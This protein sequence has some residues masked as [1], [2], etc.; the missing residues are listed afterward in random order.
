MT[1]LTAAVAGAA[2]VTFVAPQHGGQA[3]GPALIE[4]ATDAAAV[5]RVEF[6]VDGK[7]VG[8]ARKEPWRIAHDFGTS[9]A[10]R[11]IVAKVFSHGFTHVDTG[12]VTTM[13][14]TAGESIDVDLVEV[15]LRIRAAK[16]ITPADLKLIENKVEQ[17]IREIR[18][19]R[20]PANFAFIIDRSLSMGDGK[21]AAALSAVD[22]E[23][24]MLRPGDTASVILFNH[25]VSKARTIERG[26]KLAKL[27]GEVPPSGGTSMRDAVTAIASKQRT[28]AIVITDGS[29]RNSL[30]SDEQALRKI[31]SANTTLSAIV[32]GDWGAVFLDEAAKNTGGTVTQANKTT[33]RAKLHD[34]LAD[35]NS[36]YLLIYQSRGTARGWRTIALSPRKSG[37]Q[38]ASARKGYFAE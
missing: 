16:T 35:I 8:V 30:V 18:P 28:Y 15:P 25:N 33:L 7:L 20:G 3:I 9:T 23:L 34:I 2:Q 36:R 38:I 31:S 14:L 11:E 32:L 5:D 13:A 12:K 19:E 4:I 21:L 1:M 37:V 6:Y 27:F 17:Q 22:A 24:T 10:P 29:D 26:E